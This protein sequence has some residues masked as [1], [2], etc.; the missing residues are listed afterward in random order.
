MKNS[1]ILLLAAWSC[2]EGP[3]VSSF[4]PFSSSLPTTK[5]AFSKYR[6]NVKRQF[7]AVPNTSSY[8]HTRKLQRR[9]KRR[10]P[11][12]APAPSESSEEDRQHASSSFFFSRPDDESSLRRQQEYLVYEPS[13]PPQRPQ[14]PSTVQQLFFTKQQQRLFEDFENQNDVPRQAGNDH[15]FFAKQ[16]SRRPSTVQELFFSKWKTTH[17]Q[18]DSEQDDEKFETA[19]A[20]SPDA[21][22]EST[23]A[24]TTTSRRDKHPPTRARTTAAAA[25]FN[26]V[27]EN[28]NYRS[29]PRKPPGTYVYAID[30]GHDNDWYYEQVYAT[31]R[32]NDIPQERPSRQRSTATFR[33]NAQGGHYSKV[34]YTSNVHA[35]MEKESSA[36]ELLSDSALVSSQAASATTTAMTLAQRLLLPQEA[37]SPLEDATTLTSTEDPLSE[38]NSTAMG[39]DQS[40]PVE[41]TNADV[42]DFTATATDETPKDTVPSEPILEDVNAHR[43]KNNDDN[44]IEMITI[45]GVSFPRIKRRKPPEGNTQK[46]EQG[47]EHSV[48]MEAPLFPP[49]A[50]SSTTS[51]TMPTTTET[52]S[53]DALREEDDDMPVDA[54]MEDVVG[55]TTKTQQ[56]EAA[57]S[58]NED[59]GHILVIGGI[60]VKVY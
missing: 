1:W 10:V 8:F 18:S 32:E 55:P 60:A 57:S 34:S 24:S 3:L 49:S 52:T 48:E 38:H 21:L 14:R 51:V 15:T 54:T 2:Q 5:K 20:T 16:Q 46:Q 31:N 12:S 44:N 59:G 53:S 30:D 58:N 26:S 41:E 40:L 11:S 7:M 37:P 45:G 43:S 25:A 17:Q 22:E 29:Q 4:Q 36:P 23:S 50:K 42:L 39:S 33:Y 13:K 56:E 28:R 47:G 19:V 35:K 27:S 9:Q 6:H